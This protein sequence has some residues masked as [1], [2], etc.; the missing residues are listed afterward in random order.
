MNAWSADAVARR[1]A[2]GEARDVEADC[3]RRCRE[4]PDDAE[5]W[6]LLGASRHRLGDIEAALAAFAS[7]TRLAPADIRARTAAGAILADAGR[8][9]EALAQF[10]A[11]LVIRPGDPRLL[12]NTAIALESLG[13]HAEA[14]THYDRALDAFPGAG[15]AL[16]N[17]T[18]LNLR[19]GRL[20]ESC[21]DAERLVELF[22]DLAD[23]W[24]NLAE[25]SLALGR[26]PRALQACERAVALDAAF[27][28]AWIDRGIALAALGRL[29]EAGT[30]LARARSLDAGAVAAFR[31]PV[32][33]ILPADGEALD[34]RRIFLHVGWERLRRCDWRE[35][36]TF[37]ARMESL[38]VE[39]AG[40]GR[41]LR[42]RALMFP[43]MVLP[44]PV[45]AR[46]ALSASVAAEVTARAQAMSA[47][48]DRWSAAGERLRIG[49]LS[50]NFRAHPSAWLTR[51]LWT[52]H[53]R[54]R[55]EIH[56]YSLYPHDSAERR[57]VEAGADRFH[58]VAALD[59]RAVA[60]QI[61]ADGVQILVEL[62][63]YCEY[64]RPEVLAL[65][66]APLRVSFLDFPASL[67]PGLVDYRITDAIATPAAH[68]H[69]F[70]EALAR[71]PIPHF[72]CDPSAAIDAR[73]PSRLE[74]GLPAAGF[75]YCALNNAYK[76]EPR[77]FSIWMRLLRAIP[78][79]VLWLLDGPPGTRANL[80]AEAARRD[81][82]PERLVFAPRVPHARHLARLPLADLF[83]DTLDCNA[84]ASAA[85]ALIAG[86]PVLT[87]PG[88]SM[89]ARVA[90]SIVQG[91]GLGELVVDGLADYERIALELAG[92]RDRLAALR[93]HLGHREAPLFATTARVR[94]YERALERMWER[95]AAGLAPA[96]FDLDPDDS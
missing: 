20:E 41:A 86:L 77:V 33:S 30:A 96:S 83:V 38:L 75:I 93:A 68:R 43:A 4:D 46:A 79:A 34:P 27:V 81:V 50:P 78:D 12:T 53:D 65:R 67:G 24:F 54:A 94:A 39:D 1:L 62:G 95:H 17:R 51:P 88:D 5:A 63:V 52:R 7:A 71:L 32:A 73:R 80:R 66:P 44:L 42:D 11:A 22:P 18:V 6:F 61:H 31:N 36:D 8:V 92:D 76:I 56:A 84:H 35:R 69:H 70:V 58:D 3:S 14:L 29:D 28:K 72:L 23:G 48:F 40:S 55:F 10:E 49:Y 45:A 2:S 26:Y 82:D 57:E 64:A 47:P 60:A 21:A 87:C 19:L 89:A 59:D 90:A 9:P 25:A 85:D 91:A 16:M 13:R 74:V 37:L 15:D